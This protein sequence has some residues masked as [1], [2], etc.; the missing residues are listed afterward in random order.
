M[1]HTYLADNTISYRG[2][3][4]FPSSLTTY[5]MLSW[6]AEWTA[7]AIARSQYLVKSIGNCWGKLQTQTNSN[8]YKTWNPS[9]CSCH[10]SDWNKYSSPFTYQSMQKR[11]LDVICSEGEGAEGR[12]TCQ[13]IDHIIQED[14]TCLQQARSVSCFWLCSHSN[15]AG[16][17]LLGFYLIEILM[18]SDSIAKSL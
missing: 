9:Q 5:T 11:K 13:S 2:S 10:T 18:T 6:L 1:P 7:I 8:S 12:V 17:Q 3:A 4:F 14:P 15:R 16:E